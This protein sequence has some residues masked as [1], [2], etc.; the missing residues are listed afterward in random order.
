M[1]NKDLLVVT[2]CSKPD[3]MLAEYSAQLAQ[4]G[5]DH[6]VKPLPDVDPSHGWDVSIGLTGFASIGYR[7][8]R[9][10]EILD[11]AKDY[12]K[13][14][15]TDAWDVLFFG[16]KQATLAAIPDDY[17]LLAAEIPYWPEE[18]T[19]NTP[20]GGVNG[21]AT[22]GTPASIREWIQKVRGNW[23][24]RSGEV[25]QFWLNKRVRERADWLHIDRNTTLFYC[26][27]KDTGA[28]QFKNNRPFNTLCGTTPQFIHFQ[29]RSHNEPIP[30]AWLEQARRVCKPGNIWPH[31]KNLC[32]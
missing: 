29:G 13:L 5:I 17:V 20:W 27:S 4:A 7:L 16:D 24:Y 26:M 1:A 14:V 2:P 23:D 22:A 10:E 8:N 9:L 15:I 25:D 31:I 12:K 28:L 6:Y 30:A 19:G 21:G 3:L 11:Y 18:H 32:F